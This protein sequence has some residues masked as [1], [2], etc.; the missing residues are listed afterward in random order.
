MGWLTSHMNTYFYRG[1]LK[2]LRS[3]LGEPAHLT[4]PAHLLCKQPLSQPFKFWCENYLGGNQ[5]FAK[6]VEAANN[7]TKLVETGKLFTKFVKLNNFTKF[8]EFDNNFIK[9]VEFA[10]SFMKFVGLTSNFY[11]VQR[12]C[13][14]LYKIHGIHQSLLESW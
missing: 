5:P 7:L 1:F 13:K 12:S 2:K 11:E 9:F 14:R 4:G 10:N 6:F 3:H 8:V